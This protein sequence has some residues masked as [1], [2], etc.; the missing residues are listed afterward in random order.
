MEAFSPR[1]PSYFPHQG[2]GASFTSGLKSL[3]ESPS[4]TQLPA[5][6]RGWMEFLGYS[7]E[8][9]LKAIRCQ[10]PAQWSFVKQDPPSSGFSVMGERMYEELRHVIKS[11]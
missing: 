1:F 3:P 7:R 2:G 5:L 8:C 11:S 4:L 10:S 9:L 6:L